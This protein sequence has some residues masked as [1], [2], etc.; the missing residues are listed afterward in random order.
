MN[1]SWPLVSHTN[2]IIMVII[3]FNIMNIGWVWL[4]IIKSSDNRVVLIPFIVSLLS[5]S[6]VW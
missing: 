5:T 3:S 4:I 2:Q 6:K 1:I